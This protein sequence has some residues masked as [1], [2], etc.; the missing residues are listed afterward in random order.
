MLRSYSLLGRSDLALRIGSAAVGLPVLLLLI[1]AGV[2]WTAAVASLA[3]LLA[4]Y[5]LLS[6]LRRAGWAPLLNEGAVWGT[7]VV[8]AAAVSGQVALLVMAIGAVGVLLAAA[9]MRRSVVFVGDWAFTTVAVAYVGLP[10]ASVVLLRDGVSGLDWLLVAL[11]GT[12]ATD[13]AAYAVGR[14][15]GKH[16][17]A[18]TVSPGKTWEG[19]A[20]GFLGGL[21]ATIGLVVLL[22]PDSPTLWAAAA[23]GAGIGVISQAG[24]LLES[25]VKRL[26]GAK[27]SGRLI[28]GHGGLLDRLDSLV[29]VFPL[30]YFASVFWPAEAV[31]L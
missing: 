3:A 31:S 13:T 27:D 15:I 16:P 10:L 2:Y 26:A 7:A 17:M 18:P 25:K 1:W 14:A 29:L 11:L 30:V 4:L 23:L 20:G 24:D 5:E 6:L 19:A 12:F 9:A 28:P 8:A 22:E 21:G